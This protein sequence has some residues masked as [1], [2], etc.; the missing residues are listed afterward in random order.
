MKFGT[1]P[2][3][4]SA[5]KEE[6]ANAAEEFVL[7]TRP[8]ALSLDLIGAQPK[9]VEAQVE[10]YV[11]N[12]SEYA[13]Q[14]NIYTS[15]EKQALYEAK[16]RVEQLAREVVT[17]TNPYQREKLEGRLKVLIENINGPLTENLVS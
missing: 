8:E 10:A 14:N 1:W 12:L 13:T 15:K 5:K 6:E 9:D 11:S 16:S 3:F 4:K 17:A 2:P 7:A